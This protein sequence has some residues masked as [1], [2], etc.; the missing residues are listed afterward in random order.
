[1]AA[2]YANIRRNGRFPGSGNWRKL[3]LGHSPVD[4]ERHHVYTGLD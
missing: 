2:R 3:V 1:M 4:R